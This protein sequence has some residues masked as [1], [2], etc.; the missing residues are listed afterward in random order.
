MDKEEKNII[1]RN[2]K[3]DDLAEIFH[4]GEKIFTAK[5]VPTL[6]RTWDEYEVLTPFHTEP[7]YSFVAECEGKIAGFVIGKT[8]IKKYTA[9]NY[10]HLIWLGVSP[11]FQGCGIGK[12]ALYCFS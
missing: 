7:E 9:W 3:I 1:I 11:E 6:Y 2:I 8:I 10:G 4:L 5:E 12:K